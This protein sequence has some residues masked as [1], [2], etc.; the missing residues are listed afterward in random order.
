MTDLTGDPDIVLQKTGT[1]RLYYRLGLDYAPSD[2][3]VGARDE[4]FVVDREYEAVND[5]SDVTR[6]SDGV[7]HIKAGAMVRVKLTMV[8]DSNHTNMA[9]TDNLP[10]GLEALNP[11]LATSPQPPPTKPRSNSATSPLPTWF[12]STWFDHEDLHD[13]RVEAFSSYLYGGTY[14][15]T[16]VARATTIGDFVVPPTKAEEI[17]CTGGVRALGERPRRHRMSR[18]GTP[19]TIRCYLPD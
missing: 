16:Y 12:G 5:P 15:Y 7:W 14:D 2:L 10:A 9:L 17:Y 13:D 18:T 1:G 3:Q 19:G 4:G 8:A 11:E 6:D